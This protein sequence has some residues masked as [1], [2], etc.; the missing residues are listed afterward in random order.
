MY[1]RTDGLG[2]LL[3]RQNVRGNL[4]FGNDDIKRVEPKLLK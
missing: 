2:G 4:T 3:V 1:F